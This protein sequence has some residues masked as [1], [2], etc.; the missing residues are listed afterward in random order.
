MS[1]TQTSEGEEGSPSFGAGLD[2]IKFLKGVDVLEYINSTTDV[3]L[4][5]IAANLND[6]N[7]SIALEYGNK[8][9]SDFINK[10]VQGKL[11][12]SDI[13]DKLTLDSLKITELP[14]IIAFHNGKEIY[15]YKGY[16]MSFTSL[17]MDL[18]QA[19]SKAKEA[20]KPGLN[21]WKTPNN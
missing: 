20:A 11:I 19:I 9:M 4:V 21:F 18:T 6:R 3:P 5:L 7:S 17:L 13:K 1:S 14:T 8:R 12:C 15:R 16:P 10:G 2:K